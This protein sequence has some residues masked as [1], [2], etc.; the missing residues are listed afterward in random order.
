MI[1]KKTM[2]YNKPVPAHRGFKKFK[3]LVRDPTTG[4][5]KIIYFGDT[6]YQDYTQHKDPVRR[7]SYLARASGIR[8]GQGHLTKDKI[9]SPNY[10]SMRFLWAYKGKSSSS[11]IKKSPSKRSPSKKR[12]PKRSS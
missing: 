3:V 6:R 2:Q 12:S 1:L 11:P 4:K 10:W 8:D 5:D 7:D 9:T